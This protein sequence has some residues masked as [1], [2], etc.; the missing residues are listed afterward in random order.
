MKCLVMEH[1]LPRGADPEVIGPFTD[2]ELESFFANPMVGPRGAR[3]WKVIE[4]QSPQS[5]VEYLEGRN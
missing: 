1:D 4:M 5:V 2:A 3:P